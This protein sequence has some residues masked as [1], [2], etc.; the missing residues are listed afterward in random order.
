MHSISVAASSTIST[1]PTLLSRHSD[2][3]DLCLNHSAPQCCHCGYR[4][5]HADACPFNPNP[6]TRKWR[7]KQSS[8]FLDHSFAL[9][10]PSTCLASV[11][12]SNLTLH[13]IHIPSSQSRQH[14]FKHQLVLLLL[15]RRPESVYN[16]ATSDIH[17]PYLTIAPG[18]LIRSSH[19]SLIY[20][21][22][23]CAFRLATRRFRRG[24][25]DPPPRVGQF[26]CIEVHFVVHYQSKQPSS[27]FW[28]MRAV[29]TTLLPG[30]KV[31]A[32]QK[33]SR[34]TLYDVVIR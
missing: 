28:P 14:L 25:V 7:I 26:F 19:L 9:L 21:R 24:M 22:H 27:A 5:Q 4:G 17:P 10:R 6:Q 30:D 33:K 1:S 34:I 2:S 3:F 11:L 20:F 23:F 29:V 8:V 15:S 18:H 16:T 12:H 32:D 31:L 13:H